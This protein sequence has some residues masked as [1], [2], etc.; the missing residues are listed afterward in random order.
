MGN[1]CCNKE[2]TLE[3]AERR[4]SMAPN[5]QNFR[6]LKKIE[7]I[8]DFYEVGD[9]LGQGSFGSVNIA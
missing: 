9:L 5:M 4:G 2:E 6:S 1:N 3:D 8:D 7:N